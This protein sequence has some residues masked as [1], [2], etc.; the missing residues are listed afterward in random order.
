MPAKALPKQISLIDE[1][2]LQQSAGLLIEEIQALYLESQAPWVIGYSGGK[3]STAA[4]QLVWL[5]L[6]E[7][8]P[9]E[10]VT[11]VHVI[12]TDT[13]VENPVVAN[14]VMKSLATLEAQAEKNDLPI[15]THRLT[16]TLSQTFWVNLLGRGYPA[17]RHKFRWCTHRLK[18]QPSNDFISDLARK[19]GSTIL[20]LGTRKAESSAR[21]HVMNRLE[22]DR[23]RDRLSPNKNLPNCSV[24]TPLEDWSNDDVW[25]FLMQVPNPWQYDNHQLLTMYK[26]ASPDNECPIVVDTSTPSCGSSRFGCW[27]C[28]LVDK[29]RSMQAMIQ[30]DAEKEWMEPLLNFRD[31]LNLKDDRHLRDF[32]RLSGRVQLFHDRPIPGPYKQ[33]VREDW[34]RKLLAIQK[35]IRK[36]GLPEVRDVMLITLDEL[37]EIRRIWVSEKH[38]FEDTV[39]R[40]YQEVIGEPFPD[41]SF[42]DNQVLNF[43]DLSL[44]KR[45]CD[46]NELHY[47]LVRDLL[48]VEWSYRTR[49]R[50]AGLFEALEK[51]FSRS[52]FADDKDAIDR[53]RRRQRSLYFAKEG[54]YKP[55][56][57]IE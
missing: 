52:F 37:R 28:T 57:A 34:L 21:K 56:S 17:P 54:Q 31:E 18:I 35:S 33:V 5:A 27:V 29:D 22:K 20:V 48:H 3:D 13:L 53:E 26:G 12:S 9:E 32:R 2:D 10:R 43:D 49:L 24:Y 11:Q 30:N 4:L 50:R 46:G 41:P 6:A 1:P 55:D 51:S 16:P 42:D 36:N 23:V 15:V 8:P 19:Y 7:L 25:L 45:I 40:I 14:W 39:P 44:L 47:Q 38:E